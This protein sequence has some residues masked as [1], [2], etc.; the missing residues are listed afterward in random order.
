MVV[1]FPVHSEGMARNTQTQRRHYR[2]ILSVTV[3]YSRT[4]GYWPTF[5][6]NSAVEVLETLPRQNYVSRPNERAN[7]R[8]CAE[9]VLRAQT[10]PNGS[11]RSVAPRRSMTG[12]PRFRPR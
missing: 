10:N 7:T 3:R 8:P 12:V 6:G 2:C 5:F 4:K 11:W 1:C 9:I